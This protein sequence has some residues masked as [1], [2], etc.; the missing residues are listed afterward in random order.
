MILDLDGPFYFSFSFQILIP[1]FFEKITKTHCNKDR[2]QATQIISINI[3]IPIQIPI[4]IK[5]SPFSLSFG[6][7]QLD[8]IFDEFYLTITYKRLLII[9]L[10][11]VVESLRVD[12]LIKYDLVASVKPLID[13]LQPQRNHTRKGRRYTQ[14]GAGVIADDR[15]GNFEGG[16]AEVV[17]HPCPRKERVRQVRRLRRGPTPER[18]EPGPQVAGQAPGGLQ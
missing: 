11:G 12:D 17:F 10:K 7:F 16:K 14:H 9:N 13:G 18:R 3:S 5:Y 1:Q 6:I 8:P 4:N 15:E 2:D